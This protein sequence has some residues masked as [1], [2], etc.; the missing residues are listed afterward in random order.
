MQTSDMKDPKGDR[1]V[2]SVPPPPQKPLLSS[3]LFLN[4]KMCDWK[5][6][7]DHLKR[8]GKIEQAE[9]IK[10]IEMVSAILSTF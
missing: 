1:V 9:F 6:L 7:R 2:K 4:N 5:L 3:Q 8:G 10:I